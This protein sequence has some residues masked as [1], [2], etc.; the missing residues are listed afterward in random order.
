MGDGNWANRKLELGQAAQQGWDRTERQHREVEKG[1][2]KETRL[3]GELCY[4]IILIRQAKLVWK[5]SK[6]WFKPRS[7]KSIW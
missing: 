3:A 2:C 5:M 6:D 4:S 7:R 1:E